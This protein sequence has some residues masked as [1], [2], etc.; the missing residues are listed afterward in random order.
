M[1]KRLSLTFPQGIAFDERWRDL[2]IF[3]CYVV[4]NIGGQLPSC[5]ASPT[6]SDTFAQSH[7]SQ[8]VSSST[9]SARW[10]SP[11]LIDCHTVDSVI[12]HTSRW[13]P[14]AM[15]YRRVWVITED[16]G[17]DLGVR[18]IPNP[19]GYGLYGI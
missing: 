2:G 1:T 8:A 6:P 12:T 19:M 13:T 18:W 4:F 11:R 3:I 7:L 9:P 16:F 5:N 14:K 15:G 17:G 10:Q